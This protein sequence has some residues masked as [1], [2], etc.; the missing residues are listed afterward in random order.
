MS[1]SSTLP[2]ALKAFWSH[3]AW[4]TA[5][6]SPVSSARAVPVLRMAVRAVMCGVQL[7]E[8][9]TNSETY[10]HS[11]QD[12]Y[13]LLTCEK[14]QCSACAA[15]GCQVCERAHRDHALAHITSEGRISLVAACCCSLDLVQAAHSLNPQNIWRQHTARPLDWLPTSS[16]SAWGS[17]TEISPDAHLA[18]QPACS[19]LLQCTPRTVHTGSTA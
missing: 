10:K 9:P 6:S 7:L 4:R 12:K 15:H 14:H 18:N 13:S 16:M 2:A 19:I 17:G 1:S 3:D 8:S 11:C 5:A